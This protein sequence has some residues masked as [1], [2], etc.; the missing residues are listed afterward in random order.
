M[1]ADALEIATGNL[2]RRLL[3]ARNESGYWEGRLASSALSTA[4]AVVALSLADRERFD[5]LIRSGVEWLAAHQNPDG[6]WGDTVLSISNI[7][8][9]SLAWSA[10]AIAAPDRYAA[11]EA[12]AEAWLVGCA[13]SL[14][15]QELA[16]AIS[17]RYG[18]DRT[19]SI[20]ILTVL[21]LGG[22]LGSGPD[23]W[24]RVMQL[25]FELAAFP[26]RWFNRLG[27]P[28]VSYALPAL[29]AIGQLRHKRAPT[30]NPVT[31]ALR[32]LTRA[33]TLRLLDQ[34]QP[35]SGG[36]LEA[37]PLTSFVVM[38]LVAAGVAAHIVVERGVEFLKRSHRHDGSW[39]IDTNLATWVTTLSVN[40]IPDLLSP[41]GR[42]KILAWLIG[43]Q[44]RDVHA[45]TLAPPGAWA[46][47]DLPG[48][49]PDADDT[50]GAVIALH[51]LAPQSP[52]A[53]GA[54]I[55]GIKWLAGLQNA[56][57]GIPTFCRGWGKLPFDRSSPDLTA[58]ALLAWSAWFADLPESLHN[59]MRRASQ[60]AVA[61]LK[62]SQQPGGEW[63]PLWFGNQFAANDR[64]PVYGTSR[65]LIALGASLPAPVPAD[66]VR[67]ALDWLLAAQNPD[68]GWGGAPGIASSIEETAVALHACTA[69]AKAIPTTVIGRG[70]DF[71]IQ[72]TEQGS[73]T[74]PSPIGF[75]FASL[76][77]FEELYPLIFATA[78][79][80][81]VQSQKLQR[82]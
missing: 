30:R 75:Y 49:V 78:A 67:A 21:A 52:E 37:T 79:L 12:R 39:A 24:R 19:F 54:A 16:L 58:H 29:I 55:R 43:Q 48:G 46:W 17:R 45:Y 56:D 70:A 33:R 53:R 31:S 71:L 80:N 32:K 27:L 3:D 50:S 1:M 77:Y 61:Y 42:D 64:N 8:T 66:I 44:Y 13:G 62:K 38:S 4:T 25:P 65:V 9:T 81:R 34:I 72:A 11:V 47:T 22:K 73:R 7:S 36:F 59:R 6:G 51:N 2:V 5:E 18:K 63:I 26:R 69:H 28:V 35:S 76:W 41:D 68:G 20:P 23:A 15:P 82:R 10:F 40:A 74:A 14:D 57:G 60:R